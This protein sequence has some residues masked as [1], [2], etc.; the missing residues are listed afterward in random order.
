MDDVFRAV[1]VEGEER[2]RGER[3]EKMDVLGGDRSRTTIPPFFPL[4]P[5]I[6]NGCDTTSWSP[7]TDKFIPVKYDA[8]SVAS[9]KAANKAALQAELGLAVDAR[10]PLVAFVG[11]LEEQKGVDVLLACVPALVAAG[12]QVAILGTGK[13]ALEARVLA[14]AD[15]HPGRAAGVARF[16]TPLA[17]AFFAGA[18]FL[19]VPSRQEP[20]GIVQLQALSYGTVPIVGR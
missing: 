9:G 4:S 20:C 11:R 15:A 5:G 7:S 3:E 14:L 6:V 16:D 1:A 8:A 19:A 17:H 10:A 12:V 2:E 18:D 13:P